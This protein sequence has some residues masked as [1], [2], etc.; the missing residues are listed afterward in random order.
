MEDRSMLGG[1]GFHLARLKDLGLP[2]PDFVV[3][4]YDT[5]LNLDEDSLAEVV[6]EIK[7]FFGDLEDLRFA[8]RSSASMEDSKDVS[9]AGQFDSYLNVPLKDIGDKIRAV[10]DSLRN[11]RSAVYAHQMGKAGQIQMAVVVQKMVKPEVSGVGFGINVTNHEPGEKLISALYGLGEGLVSGRLNADNYIIHTDG[12]MSVHIAEK[13]EMM[14]AATGEDGGIVCVPVAS[15]RAETACLNEAQLKE[16]ARVLTQLEEHFGTPQDIEFTYSG[17]QLYV[18]QTRPVTTNTGKPAGPAGEKEIWDNSNIVESYPG[19]TLPLTYSF[20]TKMY[21]GV[22]DQLLGL[23]GVGPDETDKYQ[24]I[25]SNMLGLH[26]GRVYYHLLNWYRALAIVPGY[27]LNAPFMEKMMGVREKIS[28][29]DLPQHSKGKEMIRV[30][31]MIGSMI[32]NYRNIGSMRRQFEIDFE[33]VME[34]YDVMNFESM[35]SAELEAAYRSFEATLLR[36]WKAPMVN[37]FFVMILF[38]TLQKLVIRYHI[39]T[40]G[41][42]HNDL[43]SGS[44]DIVSTQPIVRSVEII[45]AIDADEGFARKFLSLDVDGLKNLYLSGQVPVKIFGL[46]ENYLDNWGNRTSGELKLETET[47]IQRPELFLKYLQSGL[48]QRIHISSGSARNQL[49]DA[50]EQKVLKALKNKPLKRRIFNYV[51]QKTRE[52][53]SGR[54]N[55]RYARTRGYGVVRSI[56]IAIGKNFEREG[57][58]SAY[59]DIFYLTQEE[60]FSSIKDSHATGLKDIVS[61]RKAEY[62]RWAY[63]P[64][65]KERFTTYS[66]QYTGENYREITTGGN[67]ESKELLKGLGCCP[68]VVRAKVKVVTDPLLA[69]DMN[70]DILVANHTDPGWITLFPASSGIIVEKGSLLSHSAIVS[71]EMGI[72]CIVG[73]VNAASYLKTGDLIEMNGTTGV[74]RILKNEA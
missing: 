46:I 33:Q 14:I 41:T 39:D 48:R 70:G 8:V 44:N 17:D 57:S 65:L 31:R 21:H 52:L 68:G 22:Y 35:S 60:V 45:K 25:L 69:D 6:S 43:L 55:M 73:V 32:S 36:K 18:L 11:S 40:S 61:E 34:Q 37:D 1:K 4:P 38:G 67:M 28:V 30:L 72:P 54:E 2:V 10:K 64:P 23:F 15:D 42:L 74:I 56:F 12:N 19:F 24:D 7:A 51:L 3:L 27:S 16:I 66:G 58:L 63:E 59:R 50:A 13:S 26:Q 49:K 62:A 47:Y 29:Q 5:V 53:V 9:F 20:I 71:R